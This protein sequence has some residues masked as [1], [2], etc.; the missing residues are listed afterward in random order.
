MYGARRKLSASSRPLAA[1][2]V[3]DP[4]PDSTPTSLQTAAKSFPDFTHNGWQHGAC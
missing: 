1:I 4:C 2:K 3:T